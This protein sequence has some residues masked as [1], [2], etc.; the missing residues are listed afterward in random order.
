MSPRLEGV[1]KWG[2]WIRENVCCD[3]IW[4]DLCLILRVCVGVG[5]VKRDGHGG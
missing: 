2:G 5:M 3:G 4:I 1:T